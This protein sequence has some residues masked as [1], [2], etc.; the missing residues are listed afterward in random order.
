M[1]KYETV[2][3]IINEGDDR[4]DAGE[5][6]GAIIDGFHV[7]NDMVLS[8]EPT[9]LYRNPMTQVVVSSSKEYLVEA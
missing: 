3:H 4:F 5:R 7:T 1:S 2:I 8:C 9:R 6:A